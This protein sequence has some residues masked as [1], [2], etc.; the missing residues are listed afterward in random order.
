MANLFGSEYNFTNE[1]IIDIIRRTHKLKYLTPTFNPIEVEVTLFNKDYY[2]RPGTNNDHFMSKIMEVHRETNEMR[3]EMDDNLLHC[4]FIVRLLGV[5]EECFDEVYFEEQIAR[6]KQSEKI[7]TSKDK[8]IKYMKKFNTEQLKTFLI[9]LIICKNSYGMFISSISST[10]FWESIHTACREKG[11]EVPLDFSTAEG[12][13][14][15]KNNLNVYFDVLDTKVISNMLC[16]AIDL[17]IKVATSAAKKLYEF[18]SDAMIDYVKHEANAR[19]S[20]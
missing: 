8:L 12:Q 18:G 19:T 11:T 13:V 1:E 5:I 4:I 7:I 15:L 3:G 20:A 9:N 14:F 17:N 2:I 10:H 16:D 6:R